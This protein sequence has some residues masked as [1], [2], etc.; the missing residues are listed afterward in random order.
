MSD[1]YDIVAGSSNLRSV[2]RPAIDQPLQPSELHA[3]NS[4]QRPDLLAHPWRIFRLTSDDTLWSVQ[5]GKLAPAQ[6]LAA[7]SL[8]ESNVTPVYMLTAT[9]TL[10]DGLG[11]VVNTGGGGSSYAE[12]A[13]FSALPAPTTAGTTALVLAAQGV[14]FVNRKDA[15][16][17]RADGAA[18]VYLG[19]VPEGYFTDNVLAFFDNAD[20]SK[21]MHFELSSISSGFTR[22]VTIPNKSGTLAMLDDVAPGP[23]G[24]QGIQGP[25]GNPGATGPQGPQGIQGIQGP[26]GPTGATGDPGPQGVQGP[27]GPAGAPGSAGSQGP[28]GSS[29]YAVAVAGGF[30]GTEPQWLASLVGAQGPAGAQGPIGNTGPQGNPGPQ[31]S[32]GP[33]GLQGS[34]GPAGPANSLAIGTVTNGAAAASI[35]GTAPS[36][37][38]NL[39]LPT[40]PQGPVGSPGPANTLSIGTVTVGAA[41]ASIT[42]TAPNQ[43]LNLVLQQGPQGATG[44]T[45][46]TGPQGSQGIQGTPGAQGATGPA[47]PANSLAIG[48]VTAGPAAATITGTA[49]NQTL[50]LVLQTGAQG[51]QG[52]QGLTG[53]AGPAGPG[54]PVG[55][56]TGQV[57][58]KTSATDFATTWATPA[59]GGAASEAELEDYAAWQANGNATTVASVGA[60]ALTTLGTATAAN[61]ANTNPLTRIR[62]VVY[63]ATANAAA[64]VGVRH[65]TGQWSVGSPVAGY[66]GFHFLCVAGI[67]TGGATATNRFFMGFSSL[68]TAITDVQPSTLTDVLGMGW[69]SADANAQIMHRTGTGTVVKIDL[70]AAFAVPTTDNAEI[71]ELVLNALP[72]PT[73]SVTYTVTKRSNGVSATGTITTSLPLNTVALAP[74]AQA[75]VGGTSS[76]IGIAFSRMRVRTR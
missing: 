64:V 57:L 40:G 56:T 29:A 16:L 51:I 66:G 12:Y 6:D 25:Q 3:A 76:V 47:G 32:Q 72:G 23:Q 55:G 10:V 42:G 44:D 41:A 1:F 14:P 67:S 68:V 7:K 21:Q 26:V 27:Q 20:P 33:Q 34:V 69:D 5:N 71:Y 22:T 11:N 43:T 70:G 36:Q 28:A 17:Y 60:A 73:Q 15:G 61:W 50:N 37:T 75:S 49:P 58:T 45:G 46:P 54:V 35:T 2:L 52:V 62:R 48:T 18:W 31:G 24:P 53:N 63:A 38:L 8:V 30:V 19:A 59:A 4:G 65:A 9:R 13:N 39:V 74:R